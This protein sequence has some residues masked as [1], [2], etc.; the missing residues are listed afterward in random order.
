MTIYEVMEIGT[1]PNELGIKPIN[2]YTYESKTIAQRM[3]AY[4]ENKNTDPE[5]YYIIGEITLTRKQELERLH[6][7]FGTYL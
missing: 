5:I 3:K 2:K 1:K 4:F 6:Y 7:Q